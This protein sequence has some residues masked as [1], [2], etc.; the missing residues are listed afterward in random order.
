MAARGRS[1]RTK[2]PTE[3][4]LTDP[5]EL[6]AYGEIERLRAETG[7]GSCRKIIVFK[8]RADGS[9]WDRCR[10]F[11][12]GEL[13]LDQLPLLFGGGDFTLELID[14]N[15]R[16]MRRF[17]ISFSPDVYPETPITAAPTPSATVAGVDPMGGTLP[18]FM[19][20]M[21]AETKAA[22]DRHMHFMET[23]ITAILGG[24]KPTSTK[25]L[26]ENLVALKGL[27]SDN[28]KP[29]TSI[30]S[31]AIKTGLDLAGRARG[32]PPE[33]DEGS[34]NMRMIDRIAG[35]AERILSNPRRAARPGG[36]P[37]GAAGAAGAAG[38]RIHPGPIGV[39]PPEWRQ[40]A[41]LGKFAPYLIGWA[42]AGFSVDRAAR[43]ILEFVTTDEHLAALE[44]FVR[45]PPNERNPILTQ[46]DGRLGNYQQFI[47]DLAAALVTEFETAFEAD[48]EETD[49]D[50]GSEADSAESA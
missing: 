11:A 21:R 12:S 46:L 47:N 38:E 39:L 41:G 24:Q 19:Q 37:A 50:P 36:A 1:T 45:M 18:S 33:G 22:Q 7:P 3:P 28:E 2:Q 27:S 49:S 26:I 15:N 42:R 5:A 20:E 32:D 31:E 10:Q 43:V 6:E 16:Y 35:V 30:I 25:D 9:R 4:E 17:P 13:D 44:R 34:D 29:A 8:K 40:F 48:P 23:V 14:E